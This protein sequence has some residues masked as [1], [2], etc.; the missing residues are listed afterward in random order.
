MVVKEMLMNRRIWA[1]WSLGRCEPRGAGASGTRV[2]GSQ[3]R[4]VRHLHSTSL[5]APDNL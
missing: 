1:P 2:A 4:S 5:Y 3:L